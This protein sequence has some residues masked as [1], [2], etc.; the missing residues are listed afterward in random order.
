MQSGVDVHSMRSALHTWP[1]MI[2]IPVSAPTVAPQGLA[3]PSR[4]GG[5]LFS[6][7]LSEMRLDSSR[8]SPAEG[9]F[10]PKTLAC[11]QNAPSPSASVTS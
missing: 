5:Y 7:R 1:G 9:Q 4:R 2:G 3:I 6:R 10:P 8:C 11:K